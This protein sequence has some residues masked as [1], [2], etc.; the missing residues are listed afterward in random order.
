MISAA[1]CGFIGL[2]AGICVF[3]LTTGDV[4]HAFQV[5][6]PD[7]FPQK[8]KGVKMVNGEIRTP[9]VLLLGI[10]HIH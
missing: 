8:K 3:I 9:V 2:Q 7:F 5:C 4:Y 10:Q 6:I 1:P